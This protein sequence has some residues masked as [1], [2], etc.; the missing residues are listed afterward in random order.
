MDHSQANPESRERGT[1][2]TTQIN[3]GL[4]TGVILGALEELA[5]EQARGEI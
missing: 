5:I 3:I 2:L 4:G 1:S